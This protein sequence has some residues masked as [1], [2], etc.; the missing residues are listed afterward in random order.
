MNIQYRAIVSFLSIL[1]F[2]SNMTMGQESKPYNFLF[3]AV[4]DLNDWTG[5]AGGHPQTQTP[6]MD[7][8]AAE[9]MVF[10]KAYCAAAVCNPSRAALMTG[11][12]PSSSG[13]YGNQN[14]FRDSEV[15]KNM[16][17][18]P[19]YLAKYG[20]KTMARGK[21]FHNPNGPWANAEVWGEYEKTNGYFGRAKKESGK[22]A[23]GIPIG[24]V[25][26]NLE[27]GP[28]DAKF[29]ET[30]DYLNAAWAAD[31]LK[32][33]QEA[34]FF[35]ACGITRPHLKW[36]VPKE[37]FDKFP[38]EEMIVPEI[39][40]SD[41]ED[42][43]SASRVK[44]KNYYG[45]KKYNKEQAAV[46]AYLANINYADACI[47]VVLDA[48]AKSPYA[49]NTVVILWGDHG[50]HLGEKLHYK[51]ATL[52]EEATRVPL[53]I[54]VPGVTAAGST[55]SRT[56]NLMDLYPTIVSL[57]DLPDKETNE[58]NDIMPLLENPQSEWSFPSLTTQGENRHSVRDERYRYIRYE[59]GSEEL[60]DHSTDSLEWVNLAGQAEYA[61]IK[62][63][64][65]KSLP[66]TN[67]P[68]VKR[69]KH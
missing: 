46:Q 35:L 16:E 61:A 29:E 33:E 57:A 8:L 48:L 56:V 10:E 27:W 38:E 44:T 25:D 19:E 36:E 67:V 50:W 28:T 1:F 31:Q 41:L 20:Y 54:K 63:R 2:A 3:I 58:G 24:E 39:L 60:Y 23:N 7:S 53:I 18:I 49:D 65:A 5:F 32:K 11:V 37:F 68:E 45:V 47:G 66:T 34:P 52:W 21:I 51:K 30:S 55:C 62:M 64:L 6:Y 14:Y 15:L 22:M 12:R 26:A 9:S 13:V 17:T 43:P 40:E 4:D 69:T 59:D 42:V